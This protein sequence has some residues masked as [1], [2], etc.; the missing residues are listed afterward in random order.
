MS[1]RL[2]QRQYQTHERELARQ[3]QERDRE[4]MA[5][6]M[7]LRT[8]ITSTSTTLSNLISS[9][10]RPEL[11]GAQRTGT[12]NDTLAVQAAINYA[13]RLYLIDGQIRTV[14]LSPG[15]YLLGASAETTVL[16]NEGVTVTA[17]SMC[18]VLY[19]GVDLVGAGRNLTTLRAISP[20]TTVLMP[21]ARTNGNIS[22]FCV[23]GQW[24]GT[25]FGHGI[26][27]V[28]RVGDTD[29]LLK[30]FAIRRIRAENVAS[31]GIGLQAGDTDNVTLED[32]QIENIGADGLDLK[33]RGATHEGP[34]LFVNNVSV[35]SHGQRVVG[36]AGIDVRGRARITNYYCYDCGTDGLEQVG[37]RF[38]TKSTEDPDAWAQYS[39]IENFYIECND[40]A[41]ISGF[42]IGSANCVAAN[43]IVRGA[44]AK[45]G[46][47]A[48]G[49]PDNVTLADITVIDAPEYG[50]EI[51]ADVDHVTLTAC[52]AV[53]ATTA[54]FRNEGN[55]TTFMG[56]S[57]PG[58]PATYSTSSV[59]APTEKNMGRNGANWLT[60][61]GGSSFAE[62]IAKGDDTNVD[63]R[64]TPKGTG[65]IEMRS[66]GFRALRAT[67]PSGTM[68]NWLDA[69]GSA[70]TV[71]PSMVANGS[72]T[73]ISIRFTPKGTGKVS[74]GTRTATS[75]V[76]I[77][78]Y[79]EIED[80][81]GTV[82]RLAVID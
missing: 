54:G 13:R 41:G 32:I 79:I 71:P 22:D 28:S 66:R 20:S 67:N 19:E 46:G 16:L 3:L 25:G 61:S 73:N 53:N 68:A 15:V 65:A 59:A 6:A 75:D 27:T 29:P 49:S 38:R 39:T 31:Y 69:N 64:L 45:V 30:N 55:Y 51:S 34:A 10:I 9:V 43:G 40:F 77:T 14:V 80:S 72:D 70:T 37:F 8:S 18:L 50:F 35:K 33:C 63:I 42:Q 60:E 5:E 36:S 44:P 11:F 76:A 58:S 82:R 1:T 47:N 17:G 62:L 52:K 12:V 56:C 2:T 26:F 23:D 78:G 57:A 74:F 7:A 24:A 4:V 48:N 81:G 21:L